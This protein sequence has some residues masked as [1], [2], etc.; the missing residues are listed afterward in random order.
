MS[1][2]HSQNFRRL[3]ASMFDHLDNGRCVLFAGSG[4]SAWGNLPTW[5][6]LL[7]FVV[8]KFG[9]EEPGSPDLEELRNL[10]DQG[11]FLQ[12]ADFC[13]DKLGQHLYGEVLAN[14]LRGDNIDIP[15]PHKILVYLPFS[16]VITTNYDK[17]IEKAYITLKGAMPKTPTHK[18]TDMLGSLLFNNQFFI[19]K[20]HGDIDRSESLIFTAQDYRDLI[21][22]NP[23]FNMLFSAILLTKAIFFIGYSMSDPDFRLLLDHQLATFKGN[24]PERYALMSG[25]GHVERE[26]LWRTAKIR[27]VSCEHSEFLTFLESLRD[28]YLLYKAGML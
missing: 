25:V 9:N 26:V 23:A 12:V 27:V 4:L 6:N 5:K 22:S 3:P 2:D 10:V 20:A 19:L 17:L 16:A 13:K 1:I 7:H 28:D 24:V 18:D 21:H 14:H 11:K 8:D 15:D